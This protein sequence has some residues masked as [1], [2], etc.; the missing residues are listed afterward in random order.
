MI[1]EVIMAVNI[2][3]RVCRNVTLC[4]IVSGYRSSPEI[5]LNVMVKTTASSE[6]MVN[7]YQI[8]Y[9]SAHKMTHVLFTFSFNITQPR[10]I[11]FRLSRI[12]AFVSSYS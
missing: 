7:T 10:V 2:K 3:R 11:K 6:N 8:K 4:S 12:I 1:L 5:V 9:H